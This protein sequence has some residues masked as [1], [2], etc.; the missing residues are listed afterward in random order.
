M[1]KGAEAKARTPFLAVCLPK[2]GD[3]KRLFFSVAAA[4]PPRAKRVVPTTAAIRVE[5]VPGED[6]SVAAEATAVPATPNPAPQLFPVP[7]KEAPKAK[8]AKAAP[9][10]AKVTGVAHWNPVEIAVCWPPAHSPRGSCTHQ[11]CDRERFALCYQQAAAL[12][13]V[14]ACERYGES[15]EL[16]RIQIANDTYGSMLDSIVGPNGDGVGGKYT[17]KTSAG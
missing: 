13:W 9:A 7:G 16:K 6:G 5:E 2:T 4:M 8:K 3:V 17:S 12:A 15:T 14:G 11:N 10:A 1:G